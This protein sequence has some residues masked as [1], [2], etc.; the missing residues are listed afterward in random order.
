MTEAINL[1]EEGK[2]ST[3]TELVTQP[4]CA[5]YERQSKTTAI[6][7]HKSRLLKSNYPL[8]AVI[9]DIMYNAMQII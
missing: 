9:V 4:L 6:Q 5:A 1:C 3:V 8:I 7:E 2:E